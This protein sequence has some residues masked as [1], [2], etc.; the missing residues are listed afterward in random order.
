MHCTNSVLSRTF[1]FLSLKILFFLTFSSEILP[2]RKPL[3]FLEFQHELPHVGTK[4]FKAV[5]V[6]EIKFDKN[7]KPIGIL[8]QPMSKN[9][10]IALTRLDEVDVYSPDCKFF[11]LVEN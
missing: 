8:I 1:N 7:A 2:K 11:P 6:Q 10:V 3:N 4:F 9:I 5:K